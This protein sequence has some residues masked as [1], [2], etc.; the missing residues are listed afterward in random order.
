VNYKEALLPKT[1]TIQERKYFIDRRYRF[2]R[3]YSVTGRLI[4]RIWAW[5]TGEWNW[6]GRK[7]STWVKKFSGPLW[8]PKIQHGLAWDQTRYYPD[9]CPDWLGKITKI[10]TSV[11]SVRMEIRTEYLPKTRQN[12]AHLNVSLPLIFLQLV[13]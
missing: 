9:I 3:I 6:K 1:A 2:L 5:S 10:S 13:E 4:V 12:F 11:P 7:G 8:P